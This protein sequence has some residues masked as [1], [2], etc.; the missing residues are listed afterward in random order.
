CVLL[1]L[2]ATL[3]FAAAQKSA[4][5]Q[6]PPK[7]Q[8]FLD[9]INV[10]V[11]HI[12]TDKNLKYDY[13]IVYVRPPRRGDQGR[14]VWTEIAHPALLHPGAALV[15]L[16]PAGTEAVLFEGGETASVTDPLA[17]FDG[18]WVFYSHIRGLKGTS[19]HGQPPFG[20]ADIYKIHVKT[21]K[22]VRL[23]HQVFTPN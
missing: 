16:H 20:G 10:E 19:Q 23:T 2:L 22:I 11:P 15:L 13:D 1:T 9:P 3:S 6:A 21:R 14:T 12:S 4:G 7:E 18:Q 8:L 5:R 17:S